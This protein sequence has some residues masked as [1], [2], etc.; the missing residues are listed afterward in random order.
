MKISISRGVK[1]AAVFI[2]LAIFFYIINFMIFHDSRDIFFYLTNDIAFLFLQ[3]WLVT[4]V[5][6]SIL[7]ERDKKDKMRK[8]NMVIGTFFS[9]VGR[10]LL[11]TLATA[12]ATSE[13]IAKHLSIPDNWSDTKIRDL[14]RTVDNY[15]A[16]VDSRLC[17]LDCLKTFLLEKRSFVLT[18]LS[19]GNLLEHEIFTNILWAVLHMEEE[20]NFRPSLTNLSSEDFAHLSGDINRV[21]AHLIKEWA[22]YMYHLRKSYPYLFSLEIRT[23]PFNKNANIYVTT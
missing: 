19:N 15:N 5:I 10:E 20:L 3:V 12:D 16:S 11:K 2:G 21:Y 7:T 17:K 18:L 8:L 4:I 1:Q 22:R 6:Q 23:N 13:T 9:E 14:L